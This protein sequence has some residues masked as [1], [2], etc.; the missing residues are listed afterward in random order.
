MLND[1]SRY[2]FPR[3]KQGKLQLR[4]PVPR[5][6]HGR[7]LH[8]RTGKLCKELTRKL[9]TTDREHAVKVRSPNTR[10]VGE[11]ISSL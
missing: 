5:P 1:L 8:P 4:V 9:G 3:G 10:R 11:A 6:L 2:I 7:F